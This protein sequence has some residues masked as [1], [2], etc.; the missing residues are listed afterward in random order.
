MTKKKIYFLIG[1]SKIDFD[2]SCKEVLAIVQSLAAKKQ[3]KDP[4]EVLVTSGWW[5]SFRKRQPQ[6]TVRCLSYVYAVAHDPESSK[7]TFIFW[8]RL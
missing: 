2:K 5:N 4:E 7:A 1:C 3:G 6:F 8:R